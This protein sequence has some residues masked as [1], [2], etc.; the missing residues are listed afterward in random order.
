LMTCLKMVVDHLQAL[1]TNPALS[2][3]A[4]LQAVSP[5]VCIASIGTLRC[6]VL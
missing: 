4:S 2:E 3:V 6:F 5:R 1:S